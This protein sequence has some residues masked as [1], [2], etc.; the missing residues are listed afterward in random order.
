MEAEKRSIAKRSAILFLPRQRL[1]LVPARTRLRRIPAD[2][3][4]TATTTSIPTSTTTIPNQNP[5]SLTLCPT[6]KTRILRIQNNATKQKQ[7]Q[8]IQKQRDN[9]SAN[10]SFR[11]KATSLLEAHQLLSPRKNR[12]EHGSDLAKQQYVLCAKRV[13]VRK[14]MAITTTTTTTQQQPSWT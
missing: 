6:T 14:P 7:R 5:R 12:I 13:P 10:Q 3:P 4:E 11:R 9:G 1:W 8:M 2:P